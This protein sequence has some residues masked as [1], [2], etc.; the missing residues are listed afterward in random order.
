MSSFCQ[1]VTMFMVC[2]CVCVCVSVSVCVFLTIH[3]AKKGECC[4]SEAF[5]LT[6]LVGVRLGINQ[7]YFCPEYG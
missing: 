4:L 1:S 7:S 5:L 3:V 2:V 6:F